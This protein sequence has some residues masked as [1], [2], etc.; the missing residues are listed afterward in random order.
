M[1]AAA[2]E[3]PDSIT[4]YDVIG[5]GT[6]RGTFS[7][8]VTD[9][10]RLRAAHLSP[11]NR[12]LVKAMALVKHAR[13]DSTVWC[14]PELGTAG[15][16]GNT[17]RISRRGITL[18][19]LKESYTLDPDG[20]DVQVHAFER[21]GPIPF[22]LRNEKRHP[23][24]IHAH[25]MSSTYWI[26]LLGADWTADYTVAPTR[27]HIDGHLKSPWGEAL[28]VIDKRHD[29]PPHR[30]QRTGPLRDLEHRLATRAF[31]LEAAKDSRCVFAYAYAIMTRRIADD[32][33]RNPDIDGAWITALA[34]A[35]SARY[36]AALDASTATR[37]PAWQAAFDAMNARTSVLE[38]L[39]IAMAVHIA[40]DL[41]L[42]LQDVDPLPGHIGDY[43][44][45]NDMLGHAIT[46]IQRDVAKRYSPYIRFLDQLAGKEDEILT[47]YGVRLSRG[48]AWYNAARIAL[49]V[50]SADGRASV[51]R[52]A[53]MFVRD[54]VDPP[55]W[56]LRQGLRLFRLAVVYLRRWPRA[57]AMR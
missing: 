17:V 31:E 40:H 15:I 2:G 8:R 34:D 30:A 1:S 23:A 42:A 14:Q 13:I 9:P 50:T 22:L 45:V 33:E 11:K 26:P 5:R 43:H 49:P 44:A 4:Y 16:A 37:A 48:M 28:E 57:E 36:V 3:A 12:V 10:D 6:W 27:R 24:Q 41:P 25:G 21:F 56:S 29:A 46:T 35:F 19:L 55:N 18:Y 20:S 52:T 38:D 51:E 32:L 53:V 39:I 47:N 7:F 54:L